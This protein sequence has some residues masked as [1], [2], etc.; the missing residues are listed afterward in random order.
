MR[1]TVTRLTAFL[2]AATALPAYAATTTDKPTSAVPPPG[3]S[4]HSATTATSGKAQ[5]GGPSSTIHPGP[6]YNHGSANVGNSSENNGMPGSQGAA[7][8]ATMQDGHSSNR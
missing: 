6:A 2:L 5:P 8:S 3:L 4:H 7:A 1:S